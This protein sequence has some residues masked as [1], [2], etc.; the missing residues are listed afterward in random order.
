MHTFKRIIYFIWRVYPT[1]SIAFK[2]RMDSLTCPCFLGF[3]WDFLLHTQ[4]G[5]SVYFLVQAFHY[6]TSRFS[7]TCHTLFYI[8]IIWNLQSAQTLKVV[9]NLKVTC[10]MH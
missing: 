2:E 6:F 1:D 5:F 3:R 7:L 4:C 10:A 9:Y 8:V